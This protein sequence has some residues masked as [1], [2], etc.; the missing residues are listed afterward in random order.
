MYANENLADK[1]SRKKKK[2]W[3]HRQAG[4]N[5]IFQIMNAGE[6]PYAEEDW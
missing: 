5:R 2:N 3:S 1:K 4:V 6:L